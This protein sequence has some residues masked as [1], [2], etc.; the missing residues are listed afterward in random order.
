MMKNTNYPELISPYYRALAEQ[1]G[2]PIRRQAFFDERELMNIDFI[3]DGLNENHHEVVPYL[4]HRYPNQALV[5]A[6]TCCATYCR[7]CFR[8]RRWTQP[9]THAHIPQ[10]A[11]QKIVD[12]LQTHPEVN[13]LLISGGDPLMLPLDLLEYLLFSFSKVKTLQIIRI[14]SRL[15]VTDPLRLTPEIIACLAR[16]P[17]LN[18]MTHFNHPFEL[19]ETSLYV[20]N[21]LRKSGI[22]LFNQTV[23]LKDINDN[24][25][26]L[27]D[28]FNRLAQIGVHPHYLFHIDPVAGVTHFATGLRSAH[29]LYQKIRKHLSSLALPKLTLDL[30][31]GKGKIIL[32]PDLPLPEDLVFTSPL[33]GEK[34]PYPFTQ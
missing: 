6:T 31:N 1:C 23:L 28:L 29:A 27:I 18:L 22:R 8:K 11:I 25:I 33:T 9:Y 14:G 26:I 30:P 20:L 4:I 5:L 32:S 13:D 12:Y 21:A 16:Y 19:T 2:D 10:E 34:I 7:F 17:Q 24:E 15:M 3:D